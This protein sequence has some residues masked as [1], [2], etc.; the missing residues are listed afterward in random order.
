MSRIKEIFYDTPSGNIVI[1]FIEE[2][3]YLPKPY[4][5]VKAVKYITKSEVYLDIDDVRDLFEKTKEFLEWYDK[6]VE[7][8][9]KE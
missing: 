1:A 9:E 2:H 7:E 3:S 6:G 5:D 4:L 8:I